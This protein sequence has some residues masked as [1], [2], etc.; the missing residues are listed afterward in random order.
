MSGLIMPRRWHYCPEPAKAGATCSGLE[1]GRPINLMASFLWLRYKI[2]KRAGWIGGHGRAYMLAVPW[3]RQGGV[4]AP[5][6]PRSKQRVRFSCL[7]SA[8]AG[9]MWMLGVRI[10]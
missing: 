4:Y 2:Y 3:V 8:G 6:L 10:K 7:K 1:A 9:S 5:G